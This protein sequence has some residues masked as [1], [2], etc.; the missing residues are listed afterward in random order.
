LAEN[1]EHES[2]VWY[3]PY[4]YTRKFLAMLYK[5]AP[6]HEQQTVHSPH[7]TQLEKKK[8]P[9]HPTH[10]NKKKEKKKG[11]AFTP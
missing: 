9:P 2:K 11:G 7:Q 10:N 3:E 6:S 8:S 4:R 5:N 1:A